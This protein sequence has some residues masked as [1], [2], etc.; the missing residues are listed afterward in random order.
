MKVKNTVNVWVTNAVYSCHLKWLKDTWRWTSL[1]LE[2]HPLLSPAFVQTHT[3]PRPIK[4]LH[5]FPGV[6]LG[7]T[8]NFNVNQKMQ[9][10]HFKTNESLIS[11]RR[12]TN[13]PG[14][15]S[16]RLG[17]VIFF[18]YFPE[19]TDCIF[20]VGEISSILPWRGNLTIAAFQ[21]PLASCEANHTEEEKSTIT[22]SACSPQHAYTI[23]MYSVKQ[24]FKE[25]DKAARPA[26]EGIFSLGFCPRL[27]ITIMSSCDRERGLSGICCTFPLRAVSP[28]S[29]LHST[30][31][32]SP[33][34]KLLSVTFLFCLG[35]RCP[36]SSQHTDTHLTLRFCHVV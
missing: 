9:V 30:S 6:N 33:Y 2:I 15:K 18:C 20:C 29:S 23:Q 32:L 8:A 24:P 28:P 16:S 12:H 31:C 35:G 22:K 25:A 1:H 13:I 19:F 26:A 7:F 11:H 34:L 27:S 5:C 14:C 36:R 3:P 17:I 4:R 10:K 21:F